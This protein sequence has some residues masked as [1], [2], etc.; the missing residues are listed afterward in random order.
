MIDWDEILED[1]DWK[2]FAGVLVAGIVVIVVAVLI[3]IDWHNS[4]TLKV[5]LESDMRQ[6]DSFRNSWSDTNVQQIKKLEERKAALESEIQASGV[7]IPL[8]LDSADLENRIREAANQT[9]VT[10][11]RLNSLPAQIDGYAKIQPIEVVFDAPDAGAG[12]SFLNRLQQIE[13]PHSFSSDAMRIS[14]TLTVRLDFY[15][16]DDAAF[17]E[18]TDCN[19]KVTIPTVMPRDTSGIYLFKFRVSDLK[20]KVDQET[21]SLVDVKRK[22]TAACEVQNQV[23]K[24]A[25]MMEIIN[26]VKS[27]P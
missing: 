21:A 4:N 27:T 3:G 6:A 1:V 13:I 2:K 26:S 16:F 5:L 20:A 11:Q 10:I 22:F 23:D 15:S 7:N 9:R 24:L 25:A 14:G 17:K 12:R 8:V 18:I 19:V